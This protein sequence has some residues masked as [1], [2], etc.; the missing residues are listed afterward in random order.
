MRHFWSIAVVLVSGLWVGSVAVGD[1]R[2]PPVNGNHMAGGGE[3]L[4]VSYEGPGL[5]LR[6]IPLW[7]EE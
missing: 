3:A 6:P 5:T 2:V 7:C 4:S 1:I